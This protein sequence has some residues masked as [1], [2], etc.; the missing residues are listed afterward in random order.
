MRL[1]GLLLLLVSCQRPVSESPIRYIVF[2]VDA[3]KLDYSTFGGL[4]N[5]IYKNK[6][7]VGHAWIYL[8]NGD[9]EL[10]GGH[11]GELGEA[12]PRY[13]DGV[14]ALQGEPNPARY[15]WETLD[16]GFFQKGS[17]GHRATFSRKV[18]LTAEQFQRIMAYI[19]SYDFEH[20]S[21]VGNQCTTF[22]SQIASLV[23]IDCED[24]VTIKLDP[25]IRV[26]GVNVRLWSDEEYS[27]LTLPSPDRLQE[28]IR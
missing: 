15:F 11:S 16:D 4:V 19:R 28:S 1:L 18:E 8:K 27:V 10:E 25:E 24:Q 2:H 6:G 23:G 12:Q 21:L 14:M 20:Y 9:F 17:G 26:R 3:P 13:F 22:V 5:S 7:R